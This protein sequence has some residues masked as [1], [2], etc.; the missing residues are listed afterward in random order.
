MLSHFLI[1]IMK[2][3]AIILFLILISSGLFESFSQ[4]EAGLKIALVYPELT[5]EI[6]YKNDDSFKPTDSWELFFMSGG[7]RYEMVNDN[8]IGSIGDDVSVIVIPQMEAVDAEIIDEI[9]NAMQAG[10]GI[11]ISGNFSRFD[12]EGNK[13]SQDDSK[14]LLDFQIKQLNDSSAAVNHTL[15]GSTAISIGLKPGQKILLSNKSSLFY[16]SDLRESYHSLGKYFAGD[17]E[18][19]GIVADES[20]IRRLLWFGFTFDQLIGQNRNRVLF[21]SLKWLSSSP[22]VFINY[23][24]S[25]FSSAVL[26]YKKI[27]KLSDVDTSDSPPVKQEKLNYFITPQIIEKH[28]NELKF[29]GKVGNVNLIWDDFFFSGLT[30][31]DVLKR[32]DQAKVLINRFSDQDTYGILSYGEFYDSA[33]FSLLNSEGYSFLFSSGYSDSFSFGY[34]STNNVYMLTQTYTPGKNLETMVNFV[35]HSGGIIYVDTDSLKAGIPA[36]L[37]GSRIWH[38]TFSELLDWIIKRSKLELKIKSTGTN[39]YEITI[40]NNSPAM[41]ENT[42]IWITVPGLIKN[43]TLDYPGEAGELTFDSEKKMYFLRVNSIGGYQKIS[44][45]ISAHT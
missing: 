4:S 43:L 27:E 39:D 40:N 18:Y 41:V 25:D 22:E 34:D 11:L 6:L 23:W 7:F 15:K 19:S 30:H 2:N 10:K 5:K 24:P 12:G 21:N 13:I 28:A 3:P 36:S 33:S 35:L 29:S 42:G 37:N 8:E 1:I 45:R 16:A 20:S 9:E 14:R 17:V 32:L 26:Y 38:T 44:Y 31:S